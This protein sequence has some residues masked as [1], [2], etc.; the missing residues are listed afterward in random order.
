MNISKQKPRRN[1]ETQI[2]NE[3]ENQTETDDFFFQKTEKETTNAQKQTR[4]IKK[5]NYQKD[6][7]ENTQ[8]KNQEDHANQ[9]GKN[10]DNSNH[11]RSRAK[12]I[13]CTVF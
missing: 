9:K 3:N 4:K 2:K 13:L 11:G 8:N 12:I 1:Q 5:T 7:I 6:M 10:L